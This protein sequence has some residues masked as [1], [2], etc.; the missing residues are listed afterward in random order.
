MLTDRQQDLFLVEHSR[1]CNKASI[2]STM[3]KLFRGNGVS[4]VSQLIRTRVPFTVRVRGHKV[5][6]LLVRFSA[7]R[8]K[9]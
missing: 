6:L 7:I 2:V 5:K 3:P 4:A 8:F 1:M 9:S